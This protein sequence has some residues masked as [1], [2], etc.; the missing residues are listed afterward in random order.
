MSQANG[1]TTTST[2]PD[3]G[4]DTGPETSTDT[5]T[6]PALGLT[7]D[8]LC[9]VAHA[10]EKPWA[11]PLPSLDTSD[12]SA[13]A[14]AIR[15]GYRALHVRGL[16]TRDGAVDRSVAAVM[17]VAG[18]RP[19]AVVVPVDDE[20]RPSDDAEWTEV[21][22]VPGSDAALQCVTEPTGI[23]WFRE[24]GLDDAMTAV[25]SLVADPSWAEGTG[26]LAI[27]LRDASGAPLESHVVSRGGIRSL[28]PDG[29]AWAVPRPRTT[30]VDWSGV[31]TAVRNGAGA[32]P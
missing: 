18:T 31:M 32:R 27:L 15:R 26:S 19:V 2:G 17:S 25:G 14:S 21:F 9:A 3:T 24:T 30:P 12:T 5:G 11:S 16:V 23:R 8:E 10:A 13:M 28:A 29:T 20:L 4:P 7:D 1:E 6:A 22:A